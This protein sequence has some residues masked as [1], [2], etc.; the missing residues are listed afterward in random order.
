MKSNQ[1]LQKKPHERDDRLFR[2]IAKHTETIFVWSAFLLLAG[3]TIPRIAFTFHHIEQFSPLQKYFF[4]V[5]R[6]AEFSFA[7]ESV[8]RLLVVEKADQSLSFPA[9][10][11][12]LLKETRTPDGAVV[13]FTLSEKARSEGKELELLP[14]TSANNFQ[15]WLLLKNQV[16]GNTEI[17][18]MGRT[19]Q[20]IGLRISCLVFLIWLLCF[21][22]YFRVAYSGTFARR[23]DKDVIV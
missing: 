12:V 9:P 21:I 15:L 10:E 7:K 13:P 11:D 3:I 2:W 1:Q 4:P 22:A 14:A 16:Y 19:G 17:K 18:D 23:S 20:I 5:Y 6:K 8:Y